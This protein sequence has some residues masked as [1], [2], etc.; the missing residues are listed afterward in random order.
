M[1]DGRDRAL[2]AAALGFAG[3]TGY[4]SVVAIREQLPGEPLG[5]RIPLSVSTGILVGWG[6]A[7]AAPWPMPV[8]ALLAAGRRAGRH[9]A[10]GPALVCGGRRGRDRRDPHRAQHLQ[11]EVLDSG[12]ASGRRRARRVMYHAGGRG[13]QPSETLPQDRRRVN[14][15]PVDQL[16]ATQRVAAAARAWAPM[17]N[18]RV[19]PNGVPATR[20]HTNATARSLSGSAHAPDPPKPKCPKPFG[21]MPRGRGEVVAEPPPHGEAD[22][23]V[24]AGRVDLGRAAQRVDRQEALA[25]E[26]AAARERGVHSGQRPSGEAAVDRGDRGIEDFVRREQP[27]GLGHHERVDRGPHPREPCGAARSARLV[28]RCRTAR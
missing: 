9:G 1:T 16:R 24:E 20:L 18:R 28:P 21:M 19:S 25:V 12:D 3:A 11:R 2:L 13:Y 23:D 4:N 17:R 6:S 10:V 5:I 14:Q 7:V 27:V 22:D 15:N 26:H 8:V